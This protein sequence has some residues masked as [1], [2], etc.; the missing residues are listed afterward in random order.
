MRPAGFCS[1]RSIWDQTASARLGKAK[2]RHGAAL[3][4]H[5]GARRRLPRFTTGGQADRTQRQGTKGPSCT[6]LAAPLQSPAALRRALF[7]RVCQPGPLA[8]NRATT[9]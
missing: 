4:K 8:L 9:S 5:S 7:I 1:P 6:T 3:G 2:P